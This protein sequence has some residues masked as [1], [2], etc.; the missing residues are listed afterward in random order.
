MVYLSSIN[1]ISY[2]NLPKISQTSQSLLSGMKAGTPS[3]TLQPDTGNEF[4]A[5]LETPEPVLAVTPRAATPAPPHGY[6]GCVKKLP[7]LPVLQDPGSSRHTQ[8]PA[9]LP[10]TDPCAST[11]GCLV[12]LSKGIK[13]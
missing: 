4:Q 11:P 10:S 3:S 1:T 7:L 9:V 6:Q 5:A 12:T 13:H 2:G 8:G